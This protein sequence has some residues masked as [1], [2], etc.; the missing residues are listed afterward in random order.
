MIGSQLKKVI[1]LAAAL[2]TSL[3]P[4]YMLSLTVF[5]GFCHISV[6]Q[7][8]PYGA[9]TT[10]CFGAG[11]SILPTHARQPQGLAQRC[12]S[13]G[14]GVQGQDERKQCSCAHCCE[15]ENQ[16]DQQG[17]RGGAEALPGGVSCRAPIPLGALVELA[18]ICRI[19]RRLNA[20]TLPLSHPKLPRYPSRRRSRRGV[21]KR[22]GMMS[23]QPLARVARV[24]SSRP[25]ASSRTCRSSKKLAERRSVS[26]VI[27][28]TLPSHRLPE[29]GSD[30]ANS[31][32][33]KAAGG[34]RHALP[35]YSRSSRLD[36][37]PF[38][39]QLLCCD[40]HAHRP[41]A[42]CTT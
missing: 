8:R 28:C 2:T 30:R 10:K 4:A 23:S 24:S 39:L 33:G 26:M 38:R 5:R 6:R 20:N 25:R 31:H 36:S 14:E 42:S 18:C 21:K 1:I 13:K 35:T 12:R 41:M 27:T 29:H 37:L 9:E 40:S 11:A 19:P 3:V 15:A 7:S 32:S 22:K 34:L 17:V 16:E